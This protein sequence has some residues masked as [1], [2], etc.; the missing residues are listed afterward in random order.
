MCQNEYE[1][2]HLLEFVSGF[3]V[4]GMDAYYGE[5]RNK[6]MG[7]GVDKSALLLYSIAGIII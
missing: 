2:S 3:A 6:Y 1:I 4:I 5:S 7:R